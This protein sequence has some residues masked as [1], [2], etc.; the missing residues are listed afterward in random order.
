M[1]ETDKKALKIRLLRRPEH[2][3]LILARVSRA[4]F[5]KWSNLMA[6]LVPTLIEFEK[7][8]HSMPPLSFFL[9]LKALQVGSHPHSLWSSLKSF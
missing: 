3:R 8:V 7:E 9:L 2:D 4:N 1:V 6:N 5:A